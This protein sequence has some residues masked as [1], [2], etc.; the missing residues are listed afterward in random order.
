[1]PR[2]VC[3]LYCKLRVILKHCKVILSGIV[4]VVF[5]LDSVAEY[6][7]YSHGWRL[8]IL[9]YRFWKSTETFYKIFY[10]GKF[11]SFFLWSNY[12]LVWMKLLFSV[13]PANINWPVHKN[14]PILLLLFLFSAYLLLFRGKKLNSSFV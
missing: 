13:I 4:F 1:M 12:H 5:F 2:F 14:N 7:K 3:D 8:K 11:I 9:F 6:F 10:K